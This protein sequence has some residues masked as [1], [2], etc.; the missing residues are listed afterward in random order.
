MGTAPEMVDEVSMP[1]ELDQLSTPAP[2]LG[3]E[4][5][6]G[7]LVGE[8]LAGEVLVPGVPV[9]EVVLQ[10]VDGPGHDRKSYLS[11]RVV[12]VE[13]RCRAGVDDRS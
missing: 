9:V 3:P 11:S 6:D 12:V 4:S 7:A 8:G 13:R 1:G 2:L 5:G 10:T